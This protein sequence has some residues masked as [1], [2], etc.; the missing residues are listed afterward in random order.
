MDTVT[1]SPI[2]NPI[3]RPR[4]YLSKVSD[5]REFTA[6]L[7]DPSIPCMVTSADVSNPAVQSQT[8]GIYHKTNVLLQPG[9]TAQSLITDAVTNG[10]RAKGY[11]VVAPGEGSLP[12]EVDILKCWMWATNT[13]AGQKMKTILQIKLRSP[14]ALGGT[15][16]IVNA[17]YEINS[18]ITTVSVGVTT[19][20]DALDAL[21]KNIP[22]QLKAP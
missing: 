12:V 4:V 10:L 5:L 8:I 22:A 14:V 16:Q 15:S 11:T 6:D 3:G 19:V 9:Q 13:D 18:P 17:E 2:T 21:S 20:A 1:L 7:N